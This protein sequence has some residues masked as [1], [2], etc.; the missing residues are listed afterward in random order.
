MLGGIMTSKVKCLTEIAM[1]S[2]LAFI[3]GLF[4]LRIF[5]EGGSISL[6]MVPIVFISFRRGVLSGISTGMFTGLLKSLLGGVLLHPLSMIFDYILAYGAVGISGVFKLPETI[7]RKK[8][9]LNLIL[10]TIL[11]TLAR[12]VINILSGVFIFSSYIPRGQNLWMYSLY[13]N[14]VT[15]F[16]SIII[17]LVSIIFL[18]RYICLKR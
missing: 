5:P 6:A 9:I 1:M 12:L 18:R 11:G 10:G 13:Y 17:T 2:A 14:S 7:S 3:F 8:V 4:R 16:P 15:L